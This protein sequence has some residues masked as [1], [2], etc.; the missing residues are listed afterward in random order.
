MKTFLIESLLV[1]ASLALWLIV[2]PVAA[3]ILPLLDLFHSGGGPRP[4]PGRPAVG[5]RLLP[6]PA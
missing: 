3:M 5:S 6:V 1:I 4:R 2:L